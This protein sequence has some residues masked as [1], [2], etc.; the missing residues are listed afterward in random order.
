MAIE[1][2]APLDLVPYSL[3]EYETIVKA[4]GVTGLV[5]CGNCLKRQY[6]ISGPCKNCKTI[7]RLYWL[8]AEAMYKHG[9]KMIHIQQSTPTSC[10]QAVAA[11]LTGLPI[12]QVLEE[13][14]HTK[15]VGTKHKNLIAYLKSRGIKCGARFNSAI[16]GLPSTCIVRVTWPGKPKRAHLLLKSNNTWYDPLFERPFSGTM[17]SARSYGHGRITG[18]CSIEF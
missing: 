13:L 14:P 15:R 1:P 18:Y 3:E 8:R 12:T 16:H 5:I 9:L 10:A 6:Y 17:D 2:I 4:K 11:M 7:N